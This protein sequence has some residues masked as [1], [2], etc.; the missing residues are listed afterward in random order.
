MGA[1]HPS[2]A[3]HDEHRAQWKAAC[4]R[5]MAVID[6][7]HPKMRLV[8]H[9]YGWEPVR[10]L[11]ELGVKSPRHMEHLIRSIRGMDQREHVTI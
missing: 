2:D 7:L 8:V 4:E 1:Q 3:F 10:L 5:R 11:M 6:R 9:E